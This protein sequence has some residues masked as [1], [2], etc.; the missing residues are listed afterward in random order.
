MDLAVTEYLRRRQTM[1]DET[2]L[3]LNKS[4]RGTQAA[5]LNSISWNWL[6]ERCLPSL[7]K[8]SCF[9]IVWM[10]SNLVKA[11]SGGHCTFNPVLM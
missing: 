5:E 8:Q 11:R 4:R 3:G 7:K 1:T 6:M 2:C 9:M 10:T